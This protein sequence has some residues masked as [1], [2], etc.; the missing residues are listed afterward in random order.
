MTSTTQTELTKHI[1]N[2]NIIQ[3]K[4]TEYTQQLNT[5]KETSLNVI[6]INTKMI[7]KYKDAFGNL[8]NDINSIKNIDQNILSQINKLIDESESIIKSNKEFIDTMNP[9]NPQ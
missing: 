1:T 5:I 8:T 7:K 3:K 6:G 2:L 9:E 4:V